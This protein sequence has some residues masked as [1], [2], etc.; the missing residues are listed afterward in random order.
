MTFFFLTFS[1]MFHRFHL[2]GLREKGNCQQDE[3]LCLL[4]NDI[5]SGVA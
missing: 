5:L 1:K 2:P 4:G 3:I